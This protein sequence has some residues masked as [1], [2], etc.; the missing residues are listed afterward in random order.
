MP[1]IGHAFAGWAVGVCTLRWKVSDTSGGMKAALWIP[2]NIALAYF[3]DVFTQLLAFT[4]WSGARLMSHS[5]LFAVVASGLLA[6][7]LARI[8]SL[9]LHKGMATALILILSHDLLDLAQH[10][11]RMPW[12][13]FHAQAMSLGPPLI[14]SDP[15]KEAV[16]FALAFAVGCG[17]HYVRT[18]TQKQRYTEPVQYVHNRHLWAGRMASAFMILAAVGTLCLRDSRERSLYEA[19]ELLARKDYKG[20]LK[21]AEQAERWPSTARPG[22]IDYLKAAAFEGLGDLSKAEHHYLE[23]VQADPGYFWSVADLAYFYASQDRSVLERQ[24]LLTPHLD[25]LKK[26]FK[27]HPDLPRYLDRIGERLGEP[28]KEE[29]RGP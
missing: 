20:V 28:L 29:V 1:V 7:P 2:A 22:R 5:L 9:S 10:T 21:A 25:L 12:W 4:H 24:A 16:L 26:D 27:T 19:H 11:D 14:P 8:G 15:I 18:G 17:L 13:P 23:S 6:I 3:P